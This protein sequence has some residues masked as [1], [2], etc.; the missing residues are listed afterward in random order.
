[1]LEKLNYMEEELRIKT[2]E[3]EALRSERKQLLQTISGLSN[4]LK[5]MIEEK[6][7]LYREIEL[8]KINQTIISNKINKLWNKHH[9]KKMPVSFQW[10]EM[11]STKN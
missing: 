3:V 6:A 5:K 2:Y 4:E 10:Q 8:N 11:G 7:D 1:M 9:N